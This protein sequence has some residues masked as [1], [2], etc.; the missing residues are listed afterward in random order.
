MAKIEYLKGDIVWVDLGLPPK[1]LSK[2]IYKARP[3]LIL[4]DHGYLVT[5]VPI[6]TDDGTR[7][8]RNLNTVV[9]VKG[10]D[11][12]LNGDD[13][14]IVLQQIRTVDKNRIRIKNDPKLIRK[15]VVCTLAPHIMD[16]C[17]NVLMSMLDL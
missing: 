13:Q 6:S 3:C 15:N 12:A 2:E 8:V 14:L 16:E 1:Q 9:K 4:T 7:S 10:S 5:V 11:I 17:D